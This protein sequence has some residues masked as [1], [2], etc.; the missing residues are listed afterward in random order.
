M[1]KTFFY[2]YQHNSGG[3]SKPSPGE[4][5]CNSAI[6]SREGT[7]GPTKIWGADDLSG[8]APNVDI[9]RVQV[10]GWFPLFGAKLLYY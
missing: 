10:G 5:Q 7:P 9:S 8:P 4:S 3:G 1:T 6:S 2:R